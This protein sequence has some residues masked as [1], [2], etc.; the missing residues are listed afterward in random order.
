MSSLKRGG[1]RAGAW[2]CGRI[3]RNAGADAGGA[4]GTVGDGAV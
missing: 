3:G 4:A 2:E 1:M